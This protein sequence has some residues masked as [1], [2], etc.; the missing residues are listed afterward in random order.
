MT[1]IFRRSGE[2]TPSAV[3]VEARPRSSS[4]VTL[5]RDL[6]EAKRSFVGGEVVAYVNADFWSKSDFDLQIIRATLEAFAH[7]TTYPELPS[8]LESPT[9][10]T[11]QVRGKGEYIGAVPFIYIDPEDDI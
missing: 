2:Q 6:E 8:V 3:V 4:S 10:L 5:A 1:E 11:K 9:V 7:A